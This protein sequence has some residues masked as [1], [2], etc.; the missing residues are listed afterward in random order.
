MTFDFYFIKHYN[1]YLYIIN[2]V[3][4]ILLKKINGGLDLKILKQLSVILV[5]SSLGEYMRYIIKNMISIPGSIIGMILLFLALQFKII[6]LNQIEEVSNFFLDNIAFF[7]VPAGVSLINSLEIIKDNLFL[8]LVVIFVSTFI[9]MY[10][11]SLV[12][13]NVITKKE[14]KERKIKNV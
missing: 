4:I 7:F 8:F 10:T 12:V 11:T 2:Y 13:Q 9:V 6:R 3:K 14:N 1:F 5:I